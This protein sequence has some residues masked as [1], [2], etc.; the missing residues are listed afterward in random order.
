MASS[1][2]E[3]SLNPV[4]I[5][6]DDTSGY[7]DLELLHSGSYAD[8]YR[9]RRAGRY[10]LIKAIHDGDTRHLAMLR[11]EYELSVGLEHP[12]IVGTFTFENSSEVGTCI[13]MEYVDG[14]P[15]SDFLSTAPD[16][17]IRRKLVR[18]LL[19]AV[20]YIHSKGIIHNDLKPENI[21]VTAKGNNLKLIDFG[22]SDDDA[23]YLITTPG[24]T[25]MYA[26]PELAA[27]SG[28]VDQR[29]D[30]YSLGILISLI[31]PGRYKAIAAKCRRQ[32]R[33]KRYQNTPAVMHAVKRADAMRW[34]I[35]AAA[36][37]IALLI[38]VVSP[39]NSRLQHE[40]TLKQIESMYADTL[41]AHSIEGFDMP[42]YS[43]NTYMGAGT[44]NAS[45]RDSLVGDAAC[46]LQAIVADH[47]VKQH[48]KQIW[49]EADAAFQTLFEAAAEKIKTQPYKAFGMQQVSFFSNKFTAKRD[50][51]V[52]AMTEP[53]C[54]DDLYAH[55]EK[56]YNEM[57]SRLYTLTE[58]LPEMTDLDIE[59]LNF[60]S[61]LIYTGQEYRKYRKSK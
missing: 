22:L 31:C 17:S 28:N 3:S 37:V 56:V 46:K 24:C 9:A 30:I 18:Q 42:Y 60:Y 29:S 51:C 50:S 39:I 2:S 41:A 10:F 36:A 8:T 40:G 43:Y 53:S 23:H 45:R 55:G 47:A 14:Q 38:A 16:S 25:A 27:K 4:E 61:N 12:N 32:N 34:S 21:M 49:E 57:V 59:E 5:N 48:D 44:D 54:K 35:P 19:S 15:L 1:S 7:G 58:E 26:S 13:V 33:N 52:A 20:S 6:W 11:R